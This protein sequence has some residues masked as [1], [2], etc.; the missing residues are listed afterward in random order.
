MPPDFDQIIIRSLHAHEWREMRDLRLRALRDEAADIAFID[1][2]DS[3]VVRPDDFWQQR[4][5][6]AS[7]EAGALASARQFV[8]IT[9]DGSWVGS[10][11]VLIER[12]G[13]KDF[14]GLTIKRSAGAIVGVYVDDAHRGRGILQSLF[15]AAIDWV[16]ERGLDYARLYVH[17]RNLRAHKAYEK[18]GFQRTGITLEGSVG[19]EIEM[20]RDV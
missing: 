7:A 14:E 9:A 20:A 17:A 15:K 12:T 19:S 4:A 11:T 10:V 16:R 5:A 1:T 6:A 13:D 18:A 8:A 2:F 3:A